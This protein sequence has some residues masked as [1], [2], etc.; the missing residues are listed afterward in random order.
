MD[1]SMAVLTA[2]VLTGDP[3]ASNQQSQPNNTTHAILVMKI[4]ALT[5]MS[6]ANGFILGK[7]CS[8]MCGDT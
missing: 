8:N 6:M 3:L 5:I 2:E 1:L 4:A 7:A